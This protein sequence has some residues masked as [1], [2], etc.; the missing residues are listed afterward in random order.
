MLEPLA[1]NRT[2]NFM[3]I[4]IVILV[5]IMWC[6]KGKQEQQQKPPVLSFLPG[7]PVIKLKEAHTLNLTTPSASKG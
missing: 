4:S 3:L 6:A 5:L 7:C 1:P 2:S